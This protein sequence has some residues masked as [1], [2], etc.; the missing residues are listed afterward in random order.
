MI[1]AAEKICTTEAREL[2]DGFC[3]RSVCDERGQP[4]LLKTGD[5]ALRVNNDKARSFRVAQVTG[6]LQEGL[7]ILRKVFE[8]DVP[9]V[10]VRFDVVKGACRTRVWDYDA[11]S[12]TDSLDEL[13]AKVATR[14]HLANLKFTAD[15]CS[16]KDGRRYF[17][18]K[19]KF[20]KIKFGPEEAGPL[21]GFSG[22]PAAPVAVG[23]NLYGDFVDE[24]GML[25]FCRGDPVLVNPLLGVRTIEGSPITFL[26]FRAEGEAWGAFLRGLEEAL[27]AA[28]PGEEVVPV[29]EFRLEA[30]TRLVGF[31]A[32]DLR[33]SLD[34]APGRLLGVVPTFQVEYVVFPD[35]GRAQPSLR[36]K[37][38]ELVEGYTDAPS[39]VPL[40]EAREGVPFRAEGLRLSTQFGV[41]AFDERATYVR[42]LVDPAEWSGVAD[43]VKEYTTKQGT[44]NHSVEFRATPA[45][46]RVV[47][48]SESLE[49]LLS[50]DRVLT[51]SVT[52]VVERS[53]ERVFGRLLELEV[54]GEGSRGGG[55]SEGGA[56]EPVA[57]EEV[58][59][60]AQ[61]SFQL[62]S[63]DAMALK[64]KF[65][66]VFF[67]GKPSVFRLPA[68][69]L[70]KEGNSSVGLPAPGFDG[71]NLRE[72]KLAF[73]P[74]DGVLHFFQRLDDIFESL[75]PEV[76]A[77]LETKK[78]V[79]NRCLA[80]DD[81]GVLKAKLVLD[82]AGDRKTQLLDP[83]GKVVEFET[84]DDLRALFRLGV[85]L[86]KPVVF[87]SKLWQNS[88]NKR[89][90]NVRLKL[91]SCTLVQPTGVKF[92]DVF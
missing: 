82:Y 26:P 17:L 33:G 61:F 39:W 74:R 42:F 58:Q 51:C 35:R 66:R 37:S 3:I 63:E 44:T 19:A 4:L 20:V 5:V 75:T 7:A 49:A 77:L 27:A 11:R 70:E 87:V 84:L 38:L 56:G 29:S 36:L 89:E 60:A 22:T 28:R 6:E 43:L 81:H 78:M 91:K 14:P 85:V 62:P 73:V 76:A 34:L 46:T 2:S 64:Q 72:T 25:C 15:L 24:H 12:V 52:A 67:R 47:G 65:L 48:S 54:T 21:R 31:P 92:S 55:G 18:F 40:Q 79:Y 45:S 59:D 41:K 57:A 71:P 83:E 23:K 80:E 32:E 86:E 1:A 88:V 50:G 16:T 68:I 90:F 30:G 69:A 13:R 53:G 9:F 8:V 10:D